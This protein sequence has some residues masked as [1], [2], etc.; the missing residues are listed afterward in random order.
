[1][2]RLDVLAAADAIAS[3][4]QRYLISSYAPRDPV[5]NRE[6]RRALGDSPLTK[7]PFLQ[8]SQPFEQGV[9]VEALICEGV[10]ST[11]FRRLD[12]ALLERTLHLHQERAIRQAVVNR[13]NL[14]VAT[15][16]GSGKTE[17]FLMP[18]L[19]DLL[20]EVERGT[21]QRPGVRALLLYPMNALAN[22]QVKRLRGLLA[23]YPEIT[24]GRYTGDTEET[25]KKAEEQFRANFPD[26]PRIPNELISR[27]AMKVQPP[28]ILLTNYAMLEYL[29]LR[30]ADT[31]FFDGPTGEFWRQVVLDEAHVYRGAKG[32][33]IAMLLRRLRD[34]VVSSARGRL[35][36]F[37]TSATL[38]DG[39]AAYPDMLNFASEV[40]DELFEHDES[41]TTRQDIVTAQH[42]VRPM[43]PGRTPFPAE[44]LIALSES[45]Q[46]GERHDL[47]KAVDILR[48]LGASAS[49][50]SEH[51]AR[52]LYDLLKDDPR[53]CAL[54]DRLKVEV[55]D[56]K[57]MAGL[58]FPGDTR[59]DAALVA[60][61]D[62]CV[63]ARTAGDN[64]P[65][66]PSRYHF[67]VRALE[68]AFVCLHEG[69]KAST[70]RLLLSRHKECPAC[71][72]EQQVAVPMFELGSCI[73]CRSEYLIGE[74]ASEEGREVVSIAGRNSTKP[75][76]LLLGA[77]ADVSAD[78]EDEASTG[79]DPSGDAALDGAEVR[80]LCPGC[81]TL[82][83]KP[84]APC[85]CAKAP[86]SIGVAVAPAHKESKQLTRCIACSARRTQGIVARTEGGADAPV[87]VVATHL[88]QALPGSDTASLRDTVGNG[89]KLLSFADSRQDAAF[90]ASYLDRTY[91]RLV[92]R[93]II[94]D[95]LASTQARDRR[96]DSVFVQAIAKRAVDVTMF[97]P[98]E[99]PDALG[100][101]AATWLLQEA[102]AFDKR[103][104]LEGSGIAKVSVVFARSYEPPAY[105]TAL[106][107]NE[108]EVAALLQMLLA[109]LR[110][111]GAVSIPNGVNITDEAFSPRNRPQYVRGH[112]S[113]RSVMAWSPA[114]GRRNKR[115]DLLERLFVRRNVTA[116]ARQVLRQ[117]W[118]DLTRPNS[119]LDRVLTTTT[120]PNRGPAWQVD[121]ARLTFSLPGN[122]QPPLR[123]TRCRHIWWHTVSG[124]CQT[125]GCDGEVIEPVSIAQLTEEH[126]AWT[127][128]TLRPLGMKVSEHTAQF[129]T[130]KASRVQDEFT[131][132]KINVLS[133]STTFEMGVDVGDVQAVLLRNVPPSPANY[134][135]R[136]GRAG[137]RSDS[138]AFVVAFA[139]RRS[140]DLSYFEDPV[141]MIAGKVNAPR[142]V[143]ENLPIVRRHVHSVAFAAFFRTSAASGG[144][145][146]TVK[147]FFMPDEHGRER[148]MAFREWLDARPVPL[149][150]ALSRVVPASLQSIIGV[151]DWAW[152]AAL[153]DED[154]QQRSHGWL[155]RASIEVK[156]QLE[157]LSKL[158]E[159]EWAAG[160]GGPA[161]RLRGVLRALESRLLIDFLASRNVLPKYGFPVDVAQM[162]VS[163]TGALGADVELSRDLAQ[164][165]IDYAPGSL[166]VA[167]KQVWKG[168]GL[169]VR[170]GLKLPK[171]QWKVCNECQHFRYGL[172]QCDDQCPVCLSAEPPAKSGFFLKPIFGFIGVHEGPAGESRPPRSQSSDT[173]FGAYKG[174][175]PEW[176]DLAL[177]AGSHLRYRTSRQGLITVV[178][179]GPLARGYLLC[180]SCGYG[181]PAPAPGTKRSRVGDHPMAGFGSSKCKGTLAYRHIGHDFLT[182]TI[183]LDLGDA[184]GRRDA[185]AARST[186]FAMLNST[187]ALDIEPDDVA[188]TLRYGGVDTPVSLVLYDA[189]PGGAGHCHRIADHLPE[190]IH[191]ALARVSSCTCGVETSC[192][193]CLR[194]FRNQIWHEELRRD[195]AIRVLTAVS[196]PA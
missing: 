115:L 98:E 143:L 108:D 3:G 176:V 42:V 71:S 141:Q 153:F 180:E 95:E 35:Q 89:R 44:T 32:I 91:E 149:H 152:V 160:R 23:A 186:L 67:F 60:L 69:H 75:I 155:R 4:Y 195:L 5:L 106:G 138:A 59:Q 74:V 172:E 1:M 165:V 88:F 26:E 40:F 49:W 87:A 85:T 13:R 15:G 193:G 25:Q 184:I 34:R 175:D 8:A 72:A 73:R 66:I 133:C 132:G 117:L 45:L 17:C 100:A 57:E 128:R 140:H 18:G 38:G 177:P 46:G 113:E 104:N 64:T 97:D 187:R 24:F 144:V 151:D 135:Q 131:R 41:D 122:D 68:G 111:G 2:S 181:T 159:E 47:G 37:A 191:G 150:A 28:H 170:R 110:D 84:D 169:S 6:F 31:A 139:Q 83:T 103:N 120:I 36:C 80:W 157:L 168:V 65:L 94:Y 147:D 63:K 130:Q 127:Y 56:V 124:L 146:T 76:Y 112:G 121:H 53:V 19:N 188:G 182:D 167:N 27:E 119:P 62:L 43:S 48:S 174:G 105:L 158:A 116:D 50:D 196:S 51:I 7:G 185:S 52:A 21:I 178:N 123:C 164:A 126:Y 148:Y 154:D 90:F 129:V 145:S 39:P 78:D 55:C 11:H 16:T 107:L 114:V 162:D 96:F 22:D 61:V 137:R 179:Q 192:Y 54:E 82:K 189:V 156:D 81:A 10:L 190:L 29:L 92:R 14:I 93:R 166:I 173:F 12:P 109:T 70:S 194:A 101:R 118:E 33:E 163:G 136:A 125:Y 161:N 171:Y 58:L 20:R 86:V 79:D 183:E 102:M 142:V 99:S 30:P 9:S 77:P 134:V